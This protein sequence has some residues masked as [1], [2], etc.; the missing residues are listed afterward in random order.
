MTS[1]YDQNIPTRLDHLYKVMSSQRFLNMQGLNN[2]IPFFIFPYKPQE[3]D[4]I[5]KMGKS[6]IN[7]LE[8]KGVRILKINLYD[9]SLDLLKTRG[10]FEQILENESQYSRKELMEDLQGI[11]DIGRHLIPE[12]AKK[13]SERIAFDILFLTGVGEVFPYIRSHNILNSLQSVAKDHPTVLWFPGQYTFTAEGRSSL[14][15]FNCLPDDAYYR[16]FNILDY[17]V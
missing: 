7:K 4:E 2:E 13:M 6:L 8:L 3:Q 10:V 17:Q 9:L 15:L 12:I 14:K 16:A 1:L 11:L 5:E